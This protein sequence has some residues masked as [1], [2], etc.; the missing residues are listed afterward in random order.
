MSGDGL[1]ILVGAVV[2]VTAIPVVLTAAACAAALAGTYFVGKGLVYGAVAIA[3]RIE[4]YKSFKP[5]NCS[6]G[7]KDVYDDLQKEL[8]VQSK[9]NEKTIK[10]AGETLQ[11]SYDILQKEIQRQREKNKEA[12]NYS[13]Q[14][15]QADFNPKT[16]S[17]DLYTKDINRKVAD[18]KT[19]AT[20][21]II[22]SCNRVS[23]ECSG[24]AESNKKIINETL[25]DIQESKNMLVRWEAQDAAS[26]ANQ[27]ALAQE[28]MRDALSSL[29]LL[30]SLSDSYSSVKL[31]RSYNII[32]QTYNQAE[33]SFDMG[34]Y[35]TA[36]VNAHTVIRN[37]AQE[38]T[39]HGFKQLE[40]DYYKQVLLAKLNGLK[41]E[42]ET[43]RTSPIKIQTES[44]EEKTLE[45]LDLAQFTQGK[46]DQIM[47]II[48][49]KIATVNRMGDVPAADLRQEIVQ[50]DSDLQPAVQK[51]LDKATVKI[52]GYEEKMNAFDVVFNYMKAQNYRAVW[53][54]NPGQD[55]TQKTVV[56]F[57]RG[58]TDPS[59]SI[60]IDTGDDKDHATSLAVSV[61]TFS[62]TGGTVSAREQQNLHDGLNEAFHKKGLKGNLICDNNTLG[63]ESHLTEYNDADLVEKLPV[64]T[65][66]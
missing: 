32:L 22:A 53:V 15:M 28:A 9:K 31:K 23:E 55:R 59:V 3:E 38:I 66:I 24:R 19:K 41:E 52:L 35:Q 18:M 20:N 58:S 25:S 33:T 43:R 50:I 12:I 26:K 30:K 48:D 64:R 62:N 10:K 21:T 14:I 49:K 36:F 2:A 39:E 1:G 61:H 7:L 47:A 51:M 45:M 65:I 34:G 56:K 37:V 57:T 6:T 27:R 40:T 11:E 60:V 29:N 8:E 42:M 54:K 13:G 16:I 4:D 63:M 5:A 46:Y 17:V 44:K